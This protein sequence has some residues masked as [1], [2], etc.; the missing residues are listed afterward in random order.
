MIGDF[1][2]R[3]HAWRDVA[4]N[5]RGRQIENWSNSLSNLS[6]KILYPT[7]P[8]FQRSGSHLDFAIASAA[9]EFNS[10]ELILHPYASDHLAIECTLR[11]QHKL[12]EDTGPSLD[13]F[14]IF[15]KTNWNKFKRMLTHNANFPFPADKNLSNAEIDSGLHVLQAHITEALEKCTPRF[16]P[17]NILNTI[18]NAEIK[19]LYNAKHKLQTK[20]HRLINR[21]DR[22]LTAQI[23]HHKAQV[24]IIKKKIEE[25]FNKA[26]KNNWDNQIKKINYKESASFFPSLNRFFRNNIK[27]NNQ[28]IKEIVIKPHEHELTQDLVDPSTLN[29]HSD[30]SITDQTVITEVISRF[31]GGI[32]R[33][34]PNSNTLLEKD[35]LKGD[36][37]LTNTFTTL[38]TFVTFNENLTALDPNLSHQDITFA[39]YNRINKIIKQMKGKTSTGWDNIPNIA[40]KNLPP[41]YIAKYTIL[42]NNAL[43]NSYFPS[44]WKKAKLIILKKKRNQPTH[45]DNL[46]PISLLP[47]I[48]KVFEKIIKLSLLSKYSN[49]SIV[50]VQQFGFKSKHST[51]HALHKLVADLHWHLNDN[52]MIGACLIDLRKAFDSV[53]HEGLIFKLKKLAL[54]TGVIKL[55]KSTIASRSFVVSMNNR[56]SK[57]PQIVS[58]GLQQGTVLSPILFNFYTAEIV[59]SCGLNSGNRTYSIAFADD[60]IIYVANKN[61]ER[62]KT[63]LQHLFNRIKDIYTAWRLYINVNK[64][65]TILFRSQLKSKSAAT[66]RHWRDFHIMD[67]EL[68]TRVPHK[69]AVKYLGVVMDDM[70]KFDQHINNQTHKANT[71]YMLLRAL[72]CNTH[73]CKKSKII[74]YQSLIRPM[75]TYACPIWF[76]INNSLMEKMKILERKILRTCTGLHRSENSNHIK[77]ISNT[78][79][80][81]AA[82]LPRLDTF[83]VKI[84]RQ[85]IKNAM[86]V[87]T[88]SL[89]SGPFFPNDTYLRRACNT[90]FTPPETF[91]FLDE[92]KFIIGDNMEHILYNFIR[93]CRN[94]RIPFGDAQP[95][96]MAKDTGLLPIDA[97]ALR[98]HNY[99]AK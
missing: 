79:L 53:W 96:P 37:E 76:N 28:L 51:V 29:R 63:S 16:K 92:N 75:L 31:F 36:S 3:H 39:S 19:K 27:N 1:N 88:N 56:T 69:R 48:S 62:I 85:H 57:Q 13:N 43:N 74:A 7:E 34:D 78:K 65:E 90:G 82:A 12:A 35:I 52:N 91:K 87:D 50:P 64:C 46:R 6:L 22:N 10:E 83:I 33:A 59:N 5:Q 89:I 77:R 15:K 26:S 70:L 49:D 86:Q 24:K 14:L 67:I 80:Y 41:N 54:P 40:L 38:D 61:L 73:L 55:I 47:A 30:T 32:N 18:V 84:I 58:K 93:H 23:N 60:L 68:N 66:R 44:A 99:F 94:K 72:F 97:A 4:S 9:L 71:T 11:L 25:A 98:R 81:T 2:A 45:L 17:F 95:L 8:T 21:R 42:I 20:I